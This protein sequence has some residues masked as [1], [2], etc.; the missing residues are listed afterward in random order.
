MTCRK[1]VVL[2]LSFQQLPH[3]DL[4]NLEGLFELTRCHYR[5]LKLTFIASG[6]TQKGHHCAAIGVEVQ[7]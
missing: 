7:G 4:R 6:T 3:L 5:A 1:G 2:F